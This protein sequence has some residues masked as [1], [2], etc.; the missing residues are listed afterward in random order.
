MCRA[1]TTNWSEKCKLC[2]RLSCLFVYAYCHSSAKAIQY[3]R[4]GAYWAK[5]EGVEYFHSLFYF[6][7]THTV[8]DLL[9]Q[10]ISAKNALKMSKN[11]LKNAAYKHFLFWI[12]AV[13]K[14]VK[15]IWEWKSLKVLIFRSI[16]LFLF[17]LF[18]S[19]LRDHNWENGDIF[20]II[21][22]QIY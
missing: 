12:F 18:L 9:K 11:D 20:I 16:W 6:Y 7:W 21:N 4:W 15:H 2:Y 13:W 5:R 8:F 14:F 22:F 17:H 3:F 19:I 10:T 1:E